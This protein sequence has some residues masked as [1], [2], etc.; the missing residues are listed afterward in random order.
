MTQAVYY[1][2]KP[3]GQLNCAIIDDDLDPEE[4]L[5]RK[6]E[7]HSPGCQNQAVITKVCKLKPPAVVQQVADVYEDNEDVMEY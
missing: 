2:V 3:T 4:T 7:A 6:L 5:L 1:R